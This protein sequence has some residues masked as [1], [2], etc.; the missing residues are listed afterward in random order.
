MDI[1]VC[2][3]SNI[4]TRWVLMLQYTASEMEMETWNSLFTDTCT[5]F[6]SYLNYTNIKGELA[7][8]GRGRLMRGTGTKKT[9][10]RWSFKPEC[11][12]VQN[13]L[14][15]NISKCSLT[16]VYNI[17]KWKSTTYIISHLHTWQSLWQLKVMLIRNYLFSSDV[18]RFLSVRQMVM[19]Y[20]I[21]INTN[22]HLHQSAITTWWAELFLQLT[23]HSKLTQQQANPT[24]VSASGHWQICCYKSWSHLPM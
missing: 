20:T 12:C 3:D 17:T 19:G 23:C 13:D 21:L 24:F 4:K 7:C 2:Q 9:Y 22:R 11:W 15:E 16:D 18:K 14:H 5:W 1:Q 8:S 6:D 10:I